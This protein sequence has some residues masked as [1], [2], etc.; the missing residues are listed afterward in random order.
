MLRYPPQPAGAP[1]DQFGTSAHTDYGDITLVWQDETGGLE[2]RNARGEWVAA[3]PLA[4]AFVVNVGDLLERWTN[5]RFA[6]NL[7]RVTNNSGRE[8]Y[9]MA[10]FLDHDFDTMIECI[11]TCAGPDDPPRHASV[12]R[13]AYIVGRFN[14]VFEYRK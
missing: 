4:G 6:S 9:S 3:A 8:R 5:H 12:R 7:H 2:V 10:L 13:G 14:N 1:G 11:E